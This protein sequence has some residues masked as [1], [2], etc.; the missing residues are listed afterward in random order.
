LTDSP[1]RGRPPD[2]DPSRTSFPVPG[3]PDRD[4]PP[5][6]PGAYAPDDLAGE[7]RPPGAGVFSLEGRKAPGLY[8]AAWIITVGGLLLY[9]VIGPFAS[10]STARL[11][12][13]LAGAAVVTLGLAVACG[14]QVLERRDRDPRRYRGPSPLLVFG[15]YLFAI[16]LVGFIVATV[17]AVDARDAFWFLV[18]ALVQ[19]VGYFVVIAALV[20]RARALSWTEMGWPTWRGPGQGVLRAIGSAVGVMLP[21]TFVA[22]IVGSLLGALLGVEA[23]DILPVTETPADALML[24]LAAALIVPIGEEVFF[25]GFVLTAW[26][27]DLGERTALIRSSVFFAL[28]HVVN[29]SADSFV[30]GASQALLQ[31]AVILPVG[32]VLGWLFLRYGLLAA[33]AGHVTYNG[34]LLFLAALASGLPQPT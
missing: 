3:G 15:A 9:F 14:Y 5:D 10:D 23:P 7:P 17:D 8:L 11:L 19:S 12:L 1:P 4:D 13:L 2:F 25:R 28:I 16:S 29:I 22:L 32:F 18:I 20:V 34:L 21:V 30:E 31:T 33:I 26:L 24:F 6:D 27:R